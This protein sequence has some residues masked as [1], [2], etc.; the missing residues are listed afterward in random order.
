M[1]RACRIMGQWSDIDLTFSDLLFEFYLCLLL[2]NALANTI[3]AP[4]ETGLTL[5]H[6]QTQSTSRHIFN[7]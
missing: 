7:L 5:E 1:C 3:S 2:S 6:V 4:P